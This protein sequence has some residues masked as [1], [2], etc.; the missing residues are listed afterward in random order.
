MKQLT[1]HEK[2]IKIRDQYNL[3]VGDPR[4]ITRLKEE[5]VHN[6]KQRICR[7]FVWYGFYCMTTDRDKR[8]LAKSTIKGLKKDL[9]D[10][11]SKN[12][13][14]SFLKLKIRSK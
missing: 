8:R 12:K 10:F 6:W 4:I 14:Q 11:E 7:L 13:I 2:W 1:T 9:I 5:S 3:I